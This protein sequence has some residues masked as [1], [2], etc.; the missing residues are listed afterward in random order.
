M[1]SIGRPMMGIT[2]GIAAGCCWLYLFQ[3]GTAP[4]GPS[5]PG[6]VKHPPSV[7]ISNQPL[8][9]AV[10]TTVTDG[11][12]GVDGDP[13]P[14]ASATANLKFKVELLERGKEFLTGVRDYTG[15]IRK[16]ELVGGDLLDEQVI[17]IKCRHQPFSVYLLWLAGDVGREVLYVD[18]QNQNR[19]IAHDGGWKACLPSFYLSTDSLLAMRDAR[20]PVTS[21]GFMGLA[22]TMLGIHRDDLVRSCAASCEVDRNALFDGRSCYSFTT[23]YKSPAESR[24]YRKSITLID[25]E[26]NVPLSSQHY[27]WPTVATAKSGE[28][29]DAS[30]LI[31]SYSFTDVH[32]NAHLTDQDFQRTHPDY[33]FR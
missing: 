32:W 24:M 2:G 10:G 19:M 14:T 25:R 23:N 1:K 31:E 13:G 16:Q 9:E 8:A 29:L 21:A 15:I 33:H 11:G 22:D 5:I 27:E 6:S 17:S 18:G 26:W 20:Y 7:H 28:E 30:T 3:G 12:G 4:R